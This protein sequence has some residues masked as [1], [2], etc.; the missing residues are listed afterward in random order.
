LQRIAEISQRTV[1]RC[2]RCRAPARP[3]QARDEAALG[4]VEN[5]FARPGVVAR[6][7]SNV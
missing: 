6:D 7:P 5:L 1:Q 2:G 3:A 4:I